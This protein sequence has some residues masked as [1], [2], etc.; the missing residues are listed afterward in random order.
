MS[1]IEEEVEIN[2]SNILLKRGHYDI[3][4]YKDVKQLEN[5]CFIKS[6]LYP[7][8]DDNEEQEIEIPTMYDDTIGT[9]LYLENNLK[10]H[11][12]GMSL[13]QNINGNIF[14]SL[15]YRAVSAFP[16]DRRKGYI[17]YLMLKTFE[18]EKD[19]YA[20][21][22]L[23]P[24]KESF[25]AHLGFASIATNIKITVPSTNF[26]NFLDEYNN[27]I[28]SKLPEDNL[29]NENIDPYF[30]ERILFKNIPNEDLD[31]F[32]ERYL[33]YSHGFV[34][35]KEDSNKIEGL[36]TY[37]TT[38]WKGKIE[39]SAFLYLN[40]IV[41]YKLLH[42]LSVHSDQIRSF[43]FE[44]SSRERYSLFGFD[45]SSGATLTNCNHQMGRIL[46]V[47]L[48]SG[49]HF[50]HLI[51]M[52]KQLNLPFN[53]ENRGK[54][55]NYFSHLHFCVRIIDKQCEWNNKIFLFSID[56]SANLLITQLTPKENN[57]NN[58]NEDKHIA[59]DSN[60][61]EYTYWDLHIVGLS[62]L[63]F[64]CI[65]DITHLQARK[66]SSNISSIPPC[67][68]SSIKTIFIYNTP[69]FCLSF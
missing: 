42:F 29:D 60:S 61:K 49:F 14:D 22:I 46:N 55:I 65:S 69:F 52:L 53:N 20:F 1:M 31:S 23:F 51:D 45:I 18:L 24:F 56:K 57:N 3:Q 21:S 34:R 16:E 66:W 2:G 19:K 7:Y 59:I 36:I 12:L 32:L 9:A 6:S 5:Y 11:V 64:G 33:S 35:N 15:G 38:G 27:K 63:F 39:I 54:E 8:S 62:S 67:Q 26:Y 68:Q 30:L 50:P 28:V 17:K 37:K 25:Y 43:T 10:A 47:E 13:R 40:E 48:L 4:T 58:N 41:K 44:T